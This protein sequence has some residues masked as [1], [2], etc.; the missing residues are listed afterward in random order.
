MPDLVHLRRTDETLVSFQHLL[1]GRNPPLYEVIVHKLPLILRSTYHFT[2]DI[3][4]TVFP[5]LKKEQGRTHCVDNSLDFDL[6][7]TGALFN[8]VEQILVRLIIDSHTAVRLARIRRGLC[9][10]HLLHRA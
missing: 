4:M 9:H 7:Q 8:I 5:L 10:V 2:A 6:L 3:S 1:V